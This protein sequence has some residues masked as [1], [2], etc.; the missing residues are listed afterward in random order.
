MIDQR[1]QSHPPRYLILREN[2]WH[3]KTEA[4][5]AMIFLPQSRFCLL[6]SPRVCTDAPF[7]SVPRSVRNFSV[8]IAEVR[9]I[10]G[11]NDEVGEPHVQGPASPNYKVYLIVLLQMGRFNRINSL[12]VKDVRKPLS[13]CNNQFELFSETHSPC[14]R[15]VRHVRNQ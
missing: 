7:R 6:D 1:E 12:C 9:F 13:G 5:P 14:H 2:A 8:D 11:R 15:F 3:R 4:A 10:L